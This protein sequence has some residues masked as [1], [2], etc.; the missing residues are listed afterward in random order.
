MENKNNKIMSSTLIPAVWPLID[1]KL[2]LGISS[3]ST[4]MKI[5]KLSI[6]NNLFTFSIYF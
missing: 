2:Y 4:V 3:K 6:F 1:T 5:I